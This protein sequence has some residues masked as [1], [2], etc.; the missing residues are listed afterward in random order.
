MIDNEVKDE[1]VAD[2]GGRRDNNTLGYDEDVAVG[3]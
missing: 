1:L 2:G 3:A